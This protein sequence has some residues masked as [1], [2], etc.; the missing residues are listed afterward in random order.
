MYRLYHNTEKPPASSSL[1]INAPGGEVKVVLK[2]KVIHEDGT[3]CLGLWDDTKRKITLE[4][5]LVGEAG[6]RVGYHELVHVAINDAGL[7]NVLSVNEIEQV[8]DA[9]AS[10]LVQ[11][12]K[13]GVFEKP[14]LTSN[15]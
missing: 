4:K 11:Y 2:K 3:E 8:C 5:G 14:P 9:V 13:S 15:P 1:K 7:T 12:R 6:E 10:A